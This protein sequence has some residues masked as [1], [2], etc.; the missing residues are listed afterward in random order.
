[1][2]YLPNKERLDQNLT[3]ILVCFGQEAQQQPPGKSNKI[4]K[5]KK[6]N[7]KNV[8]NI[9]SV[10]ETL[11]KP[12]KIINVISCECLFKQFYPLLY[13]HKQPDSSIIRWI[14]LEQH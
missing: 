6:H 8:L 14:A 5:F 3:R 12:L 1:M 4:F 9:L 2:Q 13:A 11:N 10:K 7:K